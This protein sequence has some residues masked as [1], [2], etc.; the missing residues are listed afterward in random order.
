[1]LPKAI[2]APFEFVVHPLAAFALNQALACTA[3][4]NDD[5]AEF[6]I[7]LA[8][9]VPVAAGCT[10]FYFGGNNQFLAHDQCGAGCD[11]GQSVSLSNGSIEEF[12]TSLVIIEF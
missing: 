1:M 12:I 10:D 5:D 8:I 6:R 4:I 7:Y 3:V 11:S 2:V 9:A